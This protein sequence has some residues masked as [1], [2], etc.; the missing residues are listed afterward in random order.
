MTKVIFFILVSV[1]FIGCHSSDVKPNQKAFEGEDRYTVFALEA[2]RIGDYNSSASLFNTIYEKSGKKEYLYRSLLGL[3]DSHQYK[4]L[5]QRSV[6]YQKKFADDAVL[7]RY[8]ILALV[9]LDRLEDAKNRALEL[10]TKTKEPDDYILVSNIYV[11]QNHFKTALKYL[12]S[13]YNVNYNEKILDKMAIILY[14]NLQKKNEALAY[15]E[16]HIRIHGCSKLI[17]LRLA[18]FYSNE[19]NVDGMLATYLRLYELDPSDKIAQNIIKLYGYKKEY[20]KLMIFLEDCGCDD[21]L[22]L[23]LY[24][25]AKLYAK[26]SVLAKKL[27]MQNYDP[28]YLAQSAIYRYESLDKKGDKKSIDEILEDLKTAVQS[29]P[30]PQYLNYLGYLMIEHNTHIKEGISYVKEALKIEPNSAYYLD[31]LAWGYY[32]LHKCKTA[33]RIINKVVKEIGLKEPEVKEH[34]EAINQCIKEKKRR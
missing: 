16:S 13:A 26:A 14:V 31:S 30:R 12:E 23:Q 3:L 18:G 34:Y 15:L 2:E 4:K 7:R 9:D 28:Q 11:K 32:K 6:K 1:F 19:N 29:D 25:E 8:E 21:D 24:S 27:Y 10:V 20:S 17:C 33:K 22:L 5:L